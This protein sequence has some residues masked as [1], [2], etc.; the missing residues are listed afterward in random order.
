MLCIPAFGQTTAHDWNNKGVALADQG[1]PGTVDPP[2]FHVV[3]LSSVTSLLLNLL[4]YFSAC[5][6][7]VTLVGAEDCIEAALFD[8]VPAFQALNHLPVR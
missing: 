1:K 5:E 3:K 2:D 7:S 6:N 8:S 4:G